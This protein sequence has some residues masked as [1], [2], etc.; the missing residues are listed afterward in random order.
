MKYMLDFPGG[1]NYG[2]P[3][4]LTPDTW[5]MLRDYRHEFM[6]FVAFYNVPEHKR[7]DAWLW[8]RWYKD[9]VEN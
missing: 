5:L 9:Y 6:D 3:R 7:N 1:Y 2:F 4:E 8:A